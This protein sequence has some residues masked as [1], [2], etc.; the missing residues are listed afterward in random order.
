MTIQRQLDQDSLCKLSA[1]KEEIEQSNSFD[2]NQMR[3]IVNQEFLN[4]RIAFDDMSKKQKANFEC[5]ILA[6]F[7]QK[8]LGITARLLDNNAKKEKR[9]FTMT[10]LYCFDKN[11]KVDRPE[12]AAIITKFLQSKNVDCGTKLTDQ[13]I[14]ELE[15]LL[16]K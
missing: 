7:L 1:V 4:S 9:L 8:N 2:Q 3:F 14:D 11:N 6:I 5:Q 16:K 10:F 15:A 12:N 13:E